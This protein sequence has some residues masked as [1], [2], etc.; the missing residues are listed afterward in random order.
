MNLKKIGILLTLSGLFLTACTND[1]DVSIPLGAYDNGVL[2]L[3]QGNF[4]QG[5]SSISFWSNDFSTFEFNAFGSVNPSIPL[6]DTA[7]DLGFYGLPDQS[8]AGA[9]RHL[10]T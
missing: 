9:L 2:I 1:D 6:G 5:N 10:A 3:N 4:G 7:Q 8:P